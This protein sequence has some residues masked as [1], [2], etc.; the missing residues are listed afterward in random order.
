MSNTLRIL[1]L[2]NGTG[3]RDARIV[4]SA[5]AA[6][7]VGHRVTVL[8]IR[9]YGVP[10]KQRIDGVDFLRV[11]AR[12][13][14]DHTSRILSPIEKAL[15]HVIRAGFGSATYLSLRNA[16][17]FR[18]AGIDL[19]PD[20]VHAHD[21]YTLFAGWLIAR[22][23]SAKLIYDSHELELGRAGVSSV[24]DKLMRRIGERFLIR[25]A[26]ATVTVSDSIADHLA[27]HYRIDRPTV[28]LNT[29][30]VDGQESATDV[31]TEL[32]IP[33]GKPL[34]V[35]LGG[36]TFNRGLDRIVEAMAMIPHLHVALVGPRTHK[37]TEKWLRALAKFLGVDD[38]LH[39]VDPVPSS[40]VPSF[41]RSADLSLVLV[42][43]TCLSYRYSFPN[44]LLESLF[45]RLPIVAS[46]LPEY[47]KLIAITGAGVNVDQADAIE[48][49]AGIQQVL[50]DR[51]AFVPSVETI[52]AMRR[53]YG[54]TAQATRL[55]QLY[56]DVTRNAP[57]QRVTKAD[58]V[59]PD[60][61]TNET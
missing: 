3:E 42:Q 59:G 60:L 51:E 50:S 45:A 44:K 2:S 12:P 21:L 9:E 34:A 29:P 5:Q 24:I 56:Q 25:K 27:Q 47:E 38:R 43:D 61:A 4:R 14:G 39:F 35:Y 54:W 48:I 31:R 8:G 19:L 53:D 33:E 32:I 7:K 40:E 15:L 13:P 52:A 11:G 6:A 26:A 18:R 20:I 55:L 28:V 58:A 57:V 23:T 17:L 46:R 16:I 30:R 10:G 22:R 36:L 37:P 41:V 1:A 49:A